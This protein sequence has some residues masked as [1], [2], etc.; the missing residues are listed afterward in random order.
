MRIS[1]RFDRGI[2]P[3]QMFRRAHQPKASCAVVSD[4]KKLAVNLCKK[5][6]RRMGLSEAIPIGRQ[7]TKRAVVLDKS[8]GYRFAQPILAC[9][10]AKKCPQETTMN[11]KNGFAFGLLTAIAFFAISRSNAQSVPST[12]IS[13]DDFPIIPAA[14]STETVSRLAGVRSKIGKNAYVTIG[15]LYPNLNDVYK[16]F[17]LDPSVVM[18][19]DA[20]HYQAL[21][22]GNLAMR[23]RARNYFCM[24][25]NAADIAAATGGSEENFNTNFCKDNQAGK[26][27]LGYCLDKDDTLDWVALQAAMLN[28]NTTRT[29]KIPHGSSGLNP[30]GTVMPRA[31]VVNQALI[32]PSSTK[33][34]W[35]G[36]SET[37]NG[38]VFI[39][40][41]PSYIRFQQLKLAGYNGPEPINNRR[42]LGF[43]TGTV[44]TFAKMPFLYSGSS[45]TGKTEIASDINLSNPHVDAGNY[46]GENGISFA[47]G[48]WNVDIHGGHIR[49][50]KINAYGTAQTEVAYAGGKAIQCE[51]GCIGI[52]ING[53]SISDSHIGIN[54]NAASS[55]QDNAENSLKLISQIVVDGASMRNVDIPVN[56]WNNYDEQSRAGTQQVRLSNALIRNS[57]RMSDAVWLER[58]GSNRPATSY[59]SQRMIGLFSTPVRPAA[60]EHEAK[61]YDNGVVTSR[62][63]YNV[64]LDN[65][66]IQNNTDENGNPYGG[67]DQF[68]SGY[69]YSS[70]IRSLEYAVKINCELNPSIQNCN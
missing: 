42:G 29:V 33:V 35:T 46:V 65:I 41:N 34:K 31:F 28:A 13:P 25:P 39:L 64:L 1:I 43:S 18:S 59:S 20:R 67:I 66:T 47:R 5:I 22:G 57:G 38:R 55:D 16:D 60:S 37:W 4:G 63:G 44:I 10:L 36:E 58:K 40:G 12:E 30:D 26:V 17:G 21:S 23:T 8:D 19:C 61:S 11:L 53:I 6:F 14:A 52:R 15:S 48:V 49:N 54:S 45:A 56:V 69:G 9:Y 51:A 2:Y 32:I 24:P 62:G 70:A 3:A 7:K 27:Y 50:V 68:Y